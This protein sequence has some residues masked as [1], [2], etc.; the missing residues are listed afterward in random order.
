MENIKFDLSKIDNGTIIRLKSDNNRDWICIHHS[1]CDMKNRL[2]HNKN[3][4]N[5]TGYYLFGG[6]WYE[7]DGSILTDK[8]YGKC[9][10]R[11]ED[12]SIF[13]S[14]L[15]EGREPLKST[16]GQGQL[17]QGFEKGLI[18]MIIKHSYNRI[19][20]ISDD[21]KQ[22]TM[23]DSRYYRRNGEYY[24]SITYVLQYYPKGKH[25]ENWL[26][27]VG[28]ASEYIVKKASED[29]T[30]VHELVEKYLNGEE[31]SF[32]NKHGDP[33]YNPEIWQMFLMLL[34]YI[35]S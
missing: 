14:S 28:Y 32:L 3:N 5:H 29:G 16:L 31:L 24:P 2:K 21:Y 18:N 35:L 34:I 27:Q 8:A 4:N 1:N 23:P 22:I 25:F 17:I 20:E 12:G 13:D 30:Q 6:L 26:K 19:L 15:N 11:L 33:Q 10:E 9:I 7:K